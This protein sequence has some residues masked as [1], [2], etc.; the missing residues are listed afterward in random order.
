MSSDHCSLL[1]SGLE[2]REA[3]GRAE[4][5]AK[6]PCFR[7]NLGGLSVSSPWGCLIQ[8]RG[9]WHVNLTR[10]YRPKWC[11]RARA[12]VS[13]LFRCFGGF[14]ERRRST[15]N[16]NHMQGTCFAVFK[17]CNKVSDRNV[18]IRR[19]GDITTSAVASCINFSLFPFFF[20]SFFIRFY[21]STREK[22]RLLSP[23]Q[24]RRNIRNRDT[25]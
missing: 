21:S 15:R 13:S 9:M 16:F 7:D 11:A 18:T 17:L 24:E 2:C 3:S 6:I 22:E 5:E 4:K 12:R 10:K 8:P 1:P 19:Y 23:I 25:T 14:Y 20:S